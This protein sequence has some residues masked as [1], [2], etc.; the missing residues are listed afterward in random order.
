MVSAVYEHIVAIILVGTIFVAT[1]VAV[2]TM[3]FRNFHVLDQQQLRNTSMNA[4]NALLLGIGSPSN[5]GSIYPFDPEDVETFGLAYSAQS[6][7]YILDVNKVQRLD[8]ESP[9]YIN[10]SQVRRLLKLEGYGFQFSLFR[11]FNIDTDISW[12]E[13]MTSFTVN[14]TRTEDGTPI[15]NGQVNATIIVTA[16]KPNTDDPP[17]YFQYGDY[18]YVTNA[19]GQCQGSV[20][21]TIPSGY[22]VNYAVA[23]FTVTVAG[24]STIAT[25]QRN[26]PVQNLL[27]I[28][29][30][31]DTITLMYRNGS[32][33][34]FSEGERGVMNVT[35]FSIG[36]NAS[37]IYSS[38]KKQGDK[39]TN[40]I[41][42]VSW[43]QTLPG[44]ST[45]NPSLLLFVIN[46]PARKGEGTGR[47]LEVI[48][49]PYN[50]VD[51]GKNFVFGSSPQ[52]QDVVVDL[53][54]FVVISGMTYVAGFRLWKE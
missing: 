54:R 6:S 50:L 53:R 21:F 34:L 37:T 3:G 17:L 32:E 18:N 39:I 30:Y 14:L 9:A 4:F 46:A 23:V 40:G 16:F 13:T 38:S 25:A 15:P 51:T 1:V 24:M 48:V 26:N 20:T 49:G 41:G 2:P 36:E 31:G 22:T 5:W 42:F 33:S 45:I 7:Q 27:S 29:T 12:T 19:T 11:P 28:N 47:H 43:N 8:P 52:K 10:Y 35:A 44:L